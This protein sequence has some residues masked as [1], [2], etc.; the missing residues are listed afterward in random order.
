MQRYISMASLIVL[1]SAM[2]G[3]AGTPWT[4]FRG[5]N[6]T[7][8]SEET[9]LPTKW[10]KDEGIRY[11]VALPGRGLSNPVIADGRIYVTACSGYRETRLHV[12]CFEEATGKKLWERQ[13]TA[14]GNTGCHPM[15]NMAAPTPVT[16]GKEVFCL[17]ATGDMAAL[18]RAGNLLW[19]RSI[20]GDYP[21][22]SNQVGMASSPTLLGNVI[23]LPMENAADSFIAGLDRKTGKNLW[24]LKRPNAINWTSPFP[25][26]GGLV[27]F[28]NASEAAALDPDTGKTRW[29]VKGNWST[30]PSPV[31]GEGLVFL[32][33]QEVK[34][35]RPL[36]D[37]SEPETVW[38]GGAIAGGF[39]SP[40]YHKGFL[41][42][43]TGAA[44]V[45]L[46]ARDGKEAWRQRIEGP[47]D[48]SPIVAD[49]KL[50]AVNRKG[51]TFVVELG[52]KPRVIARNDLDDT[53]ITTPAVANGC[54][55]LRSDKYLYCIGPKK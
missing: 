37:R 47:F 33:G 30:I 28:Q 44:V 27:L 9:G 19:Y 13:F 49:G 52:E 43:V 10:S 42:G 6:G 15:T 7:G 29:S 16:D 32:T 26:P 12:L 5:S 41:Y 46:S 3:Q 20:V 31:H 34:A 8:V 53:I 14:T 50:Y 45:A 18:D 48:G 38:E 1:V 36:Q 39:A 17:F 35:V 2:A 25:I 40:V 21:N 55:Y 4:G 22:V 54:L 23:L 24:K 11:K 51:R